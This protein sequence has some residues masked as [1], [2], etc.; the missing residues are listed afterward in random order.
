MRR[1][2]AL[3]R[4][5]TKVAA[6]T[7]MNGI[8]VGILQEVTEHRPWRGKVLITGVL[9]C[10]ATYDV[11]RSMRAGFRPG[12]VIE[13]GGVN[14]KDAEGSGTSYLAAL[15]RQLRELESYSETSRAQWWYGRTVGALVNS[16]EKEKAG[17]LAKERPKQENA[18][19]PEHRQAYPAG[20]SAW[21]QKS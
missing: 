21:R 4:I 8:Y 1:E 2:Q 14:I 17:T 3:Q 10:A 19:R 16:I 7:A 12:D 13:V 18:D 5:G 15:Q 9:E 6:W 20:C 11:T